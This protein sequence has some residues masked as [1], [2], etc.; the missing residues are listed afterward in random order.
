MSGRYLLDT[1]I[2]IALFAREASILQEA[3]QAEAIFIPSVVLGELYYG[4]RRSVRATENVA[5]VDA[6]VATLPILSCD[7]RAARQYG[8]IKDQLRRKGN[9]IPENDIW[10]AAIAFTHGLTLATRDAHLSQIDKL[11][12]SAW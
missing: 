7:T 2:I 8:E 3:S 10:I 6:L 11:P 4:A 9:P 12:I 5:R 1:N